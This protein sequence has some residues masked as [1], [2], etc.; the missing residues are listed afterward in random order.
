MGGDRS[1]Y[2][3]LSSLSNPPKLKLRLYHHCDVQHALESLEQAGRVHTESL[4]VQR[5][6]PGVGQLAAPIHIQVPTHCSV[7]LNGASMFM[8]GIQ[9][10]QIFSLSTMFELSVWTNCF[11]YTMFQSGAPDYSP[12]VTVTSSGQV[13]CSEYFV[14]FTKVRLII[15]K[16]HIILH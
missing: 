1:W 16:C 10:I 14:G 13:K 5:V 6:D 9:I 2:N 11:K 8:V 15:I 12:M 7:N 4:S 3:T